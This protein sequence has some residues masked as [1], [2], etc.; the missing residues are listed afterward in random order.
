VTLKAKSHGAR[1]NLRSK[2]YCFGAF[3][4]NPFIWKYLTMRNVRSGALG[5]TAAS[6]LPNEVIGPALQVAPPVRSP[7]VKSNVSLTPNLQKWKH[8][9][10]VCGCFSLPKVSNCQLSHLKAPGGKT[11]PHTQWTSLESRDQ[12]TWSLEAWQKFSLMVSSPHLLTHI[13]PKPEGQ[14]WPLKAP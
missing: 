7:I 4:S 13:S 10:V 12:L 2:A 14:H 9:Y 3:E 6:P 1:W 8:S 11:C 5:E